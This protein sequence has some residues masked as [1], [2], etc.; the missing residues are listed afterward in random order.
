[1]ID[2]LLLSGGYDVNPL[3]Y[4]QEPEGFLERVK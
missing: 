2:G 3:Q 1:M 4:G